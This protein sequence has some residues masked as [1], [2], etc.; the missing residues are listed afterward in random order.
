[1][2]GRLRL[3][4]GISTFE[5]MELFGHRSKSLHIRSNIDHDG[6]AFVDN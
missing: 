6:P 5:D 4:F 1:M 3:R 2:I